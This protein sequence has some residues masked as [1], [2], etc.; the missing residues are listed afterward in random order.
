MRF[1]VSNVRRLKLDAEFGILRHGHAGL[2]QYFQHSGDVGEIGHVA[3]AQRLARQQRRAQ[4]RQ[5]GI[6][7]AGNLHFAFQRLA[8]G[9]FDFV[10]R[11]GLTDAH[12]SGVSV[13]IDSA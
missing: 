9:Q 13:C 11:Y 3:Q 12:C 4:D 1:E 2:P 7:R 10:H 8:A 6:L 5:R